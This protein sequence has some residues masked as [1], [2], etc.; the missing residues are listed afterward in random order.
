MLSIFTQN[1]GVQPLGQ[2]LR[3]HRLLTQR[4]SLPCCE[5]RLEHGLSDQLAAV[6]LRCTGVQVRCQPLLFKRGFYI[7]RAIKVLTVVGLQ[8]TIGVLFLLA[9]L[10]GLGALVAAGVVRKNL[11][12]VAAHLGTNS[13]SHV[14]GDLLPVFLIELYS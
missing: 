6:V 7:A 4:V 8:V 11:L 9:L 3:P 2:N 13:G 10:L 5:V 12:G 14:G 1:L